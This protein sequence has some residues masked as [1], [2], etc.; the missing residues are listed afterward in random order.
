M[1]SGSVVA[2]AAVLVALGTG[3]VVGL[4]APREATA[5]PA[6]ASASAGPDPDAATIARQGEWID[7]LAA[8]SV[9][10]SLTGVRVVVIEA[11]GVPE[12]ARADLDA[13]LV[14]AGARV[15]ASATLGADWWAPELATY[16]GELGSQLG[17]NV[18]GVQ[19]LGAS[20]V[21]EHAIAQALLP[22]QVPAGVTAPSAEPAALVDGT[23]PRTATLL[24][25]LTRAG[26]IAQ[27][28]TGTERAD[29]VVFLAG[30]G[31]AEAGVVASRAAQVWELYAPATVIVV[32]SEADGGADGATGGPFDELAAPPDLAAE[33]AADAAKAGA[34]SR[35]SVVVV[36]TATLAP[37]QVAMAIAEQRIGGSGTYG[38]ISGW[39][40]LAARA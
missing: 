23:D 20:A 30:Q 22:G 8:A 18:A 2:A 7:A 19:G 32:A 9:A 37:A 38:A 33:A 40:L 5:A 39:E 36:T 17:E 24:K 28:T 3:V 4:A 27:A 1:R 35:P 13:A 10:G 25:V 16:R 29:A 6:H 15:V 26:M 31:P 34:S 21:L 14:A 11:D 12:A